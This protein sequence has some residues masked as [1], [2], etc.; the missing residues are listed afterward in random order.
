MLAAQLMNKLTRREEDLEDLLTSNVF[1]SIKYVPIEEGLIPLLSAVEDSNGNNV[2]EDLSH[3]LKVD[4]SFWPYLKEE[5]CIGCEPD[6]LIQIKHKNG[7][8]IIILVEAKYK[9]GK[10]S[11]AT[12]DDDK[13]YDQLGREWDNLLVFARNKSAIPYLLY[14]TADFGYP[15]EDI[16]KSY[17]EFKEKRGAKI[18][19]VWI[20]W[21]KLPVIFCESKHDIIKDLVEILRRQWLIFFEGISAPEDFKSIKWQF[22]KPHQKLNWSFDVPTIHW[23]YNCGALTQFDWVLDINFRILW[24]YINE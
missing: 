21:R 12:D 24:R 4:Y 7:A 11:E 8:Q 23:K 16:E 18:D 6:V 15:G 19:I 5:R 9:S 1:G 20:S 3:I 2:F 17:R 10:S 14:V 13:P 22:Q